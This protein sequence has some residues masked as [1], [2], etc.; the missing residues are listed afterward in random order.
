MLNELHWL[1]V[2]FICEY[3]MAIFV[4]YN[5]YIKKKVVWLIISI[6]LL[7]RLDAR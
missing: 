1:H 2:K 7:P 4:L 6:V 3:K 5:Y